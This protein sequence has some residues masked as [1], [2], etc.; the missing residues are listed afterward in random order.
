V[1]KAVQ[2]LRGSGQLQQIT[3]QWMGAAAGAPQLH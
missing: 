1:T 3:K 2:E